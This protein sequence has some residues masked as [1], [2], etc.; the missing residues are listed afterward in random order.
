M[1]LLII[2]H[3]VAED[4]ERFA[5]TGQDDDLRPLTAKGR[6][7]MMRGARG[8]RAIEP[9]VALF[10][11]SPLVRARQTAE[12]IAGVYGTHVGEITDTLRPDAKLDD[13]VEWLRGRQDGAIV[14]VVGHE[15][16]LGRLAT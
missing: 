5:E 14:A 7:K 16:H 3:G 15:P 13:F 9:S 4:K 6:K 2:R 10:A 1:E 8:L 11:S 12:I